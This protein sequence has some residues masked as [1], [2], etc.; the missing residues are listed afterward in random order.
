MTPTARLRELGIELPKVATPAGA[1][2][3][4]RRGG[5]LGFTAGQVPVVDGALAGVHL[6][7][8]DLSY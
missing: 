2:V 5:N 1:Y 8:A 7:P 3:A 4:A 6:R